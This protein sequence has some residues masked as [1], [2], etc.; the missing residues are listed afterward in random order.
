VLLEP[1]VTENF[2]FIFS[3]SARVQLVP[4]LI[5]TVDGELFEPVTLTDE[6]FK[7]VPVVN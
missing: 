5:V 3:N 4:P 7:V 6:P 1:L 2:I